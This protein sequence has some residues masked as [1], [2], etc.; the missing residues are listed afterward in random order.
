MKTLTSGCENVPAWCTWMTYPICWGHSWWS[1]PYPL[2]LH[3]IR[4]TQEP[5]CR[6]LFI[7]WPCSIEKSRF[8][9]LNNQTFKCQR[10]SLAFLTRYGRVMPSTYHEVIRLCIHDKKPSFMTSQ[11][12]VCVC[13]SC[14]CLCLCLWSVRFA[15]CTPVSEHPS[16]E[17]WYNEAQRVLDH[18]ALECFPR[19]PTPLLTTEFQNTCIP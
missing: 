3:G 15:L 2:V 1:Y 6:H 16:I 7:S 19:L 11:V 17:E 9:L 13:V 18:L 5:A 8:F 14:L 12:C 10:I 4:L